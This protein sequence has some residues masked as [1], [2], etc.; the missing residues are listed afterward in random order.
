MYN[1][2]L[3]QS[4]KNNN[5]LPKIYWKDMHFVVYMKVKW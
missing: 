5:E 1:P 4:V 3:S 2:K